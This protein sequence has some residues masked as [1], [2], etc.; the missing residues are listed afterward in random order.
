MPIVQ[1]LIGGIVGVLI[2]IPIIWNWN[3]KL[4]LHIAAI[5]RPLDKSVYSKNDFHISQ[6]KH[7]LWV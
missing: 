3:Y 1:S 5:I 6:P 7:M 2:Q 4:E